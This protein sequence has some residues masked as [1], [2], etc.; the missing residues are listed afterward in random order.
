MCEEISMAEGFNLRRAKTKSPLIL[1][2]NGALSPLLGNL[3]K[4]RYGDSYYIDENVIRCVQSGSNYESYTGFFGFDSPVSTKGYKYIHFDAL[5]DRYGAYHRLG[6]GSN[7]TSTFSTSSVLG[8][9][10]RHVVTV[11][12][13]EYQGDYYLLF[14]VYGHGDPGSGALTSHMGIFRIWLDNSETGE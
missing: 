1:F 10:S 6:I 8:E 2:D 7:N 13:D 5:C 9:N 4:I 11:P 12:I 14:S 3:R